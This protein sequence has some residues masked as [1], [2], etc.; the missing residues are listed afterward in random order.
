MPHVLSEK[1]RSAVSALQPSARLEHF[2]KRVADWER[3]WCL[4]QPG[5]C[6][7]WPHLA[8][9]QSFLGASSSAGVE[10][11]SLAEFM[12]LGLP[13]LA[14]EGAKLSVF[15]VVGSTGAEIGAEA[16][17]SLLERELENY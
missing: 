16:L 13:R 15:P 1:E 6:L 8:Y 9:A 4:A 3:L 14:N 7:L 10:E 2:V 17:A 5:T 12:S 11:V